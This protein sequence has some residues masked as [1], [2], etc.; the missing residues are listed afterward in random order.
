M[1]YEHQIASGTPWLDRLVGW[2]RLGDNVVIR[3]D[4]LQE[5]RVLAQAFGRVSARAGRQVVYF[6][7]G[8]HP[9]ILEPGD[10]V[11]V[12]EANPAPGFDSFS[13]RLNT[14]IASL[15]RRVFYVFDSLSS[16]VEEWA[17]D[18]SLGNF[19][20]VTCPFLFELETVAFFTLD[21]ARH[22]NATVAR[23]ENTT[24]VLIDLFIEQ[25]T[26]YVQ[27]LKAQKRFWPGMYLPHRL[28]GD[29]CV[30]VFQA[31]HIPPDTARSPWETVFATAAQWV[32][33]AH[34]EGHKQEQESLALEAARMLLG[35]D[36]H[37]LR[38]AERYF[39]LKDLLQIKQRLIGT[40]HIGGKATGMLLARKIIRCTP[41]LEGVAAALEDHDSFYVGS[42][43]FFTFLVENHLFHTRLRAGAPGPEPGDHWESIEQAFLAGHMPTD[44]TR[45][46]QEMLAYFGD[47][48]IIVRSS[49]LLEDGFGNAFAGKYHSEFCPNQ[50]TPAERLEALL[51]AVKRVYASTL[52]PD[53][54]A[55]RRKRQLEE[56]DEQMG[57]LIQRVSGRRF[58]QW[59]F[60][61]LAGV[62]F[63]RNLYAWNTRIDP[64]KGLIRL[65]FGLGTSAVNRVG[66]GYP[67]LVAISHPLL[68]PE[69]G[70]K[71][72]KYSQHDMEAID[73]EQNQL[74]TIPV[75]RILRYR[76]YPGLD[77]LVSLLRDEDLY[78][79]FYRNFVVEPG[80]KLVLTFHNLLKNTRFIRLMDQMLSALEQVYETPV[81][82][83]FTVS[84]ENGDVRINLLQCRPL[85]HPSDPADETLEDPPGDCLFE[86]DKFM[87]GGRATNVHV[88]RLH[89]PRGVRPLIGS[90]HQEEPGAGDRQDQPGHAAPGRRG[91]ADGAGSLG[92]QQPGTG[93]ERHVRGHQPRGGAGGN[94]P[95]GHRPLA[96]GL[97]RDALLPRHRGGEHLVSGSVSA[98]E[99]VAD[100]QDRSESAAVGFPP[101][102]R[103][104]RMLKMVGPGT[105]RSGSPHNRGRLAAA[106]AGGGVF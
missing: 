13:K 65:V 72:A 51:M 63:S 62:A 58:Q 77:L 28:E 102:P 38:L 49:S 2:L 17:T 71:I 37:V 88:H 14:S 95:P 92:K 84:V 99:G 74:A 43:V 103:I 93:S 82:T 12:I 9:P 25:G 79:P 39:D 97:V 8:N 53:A 23:I 104:R 80:E 41:G 30:S 86:T 31:A 59:F 16:L 26:R 48:P 5:Y 7:F 21:R 24:Q 18:E 6:R 34:E 56:S 67:R 100:V 35:Q 87:C 81:D 3:T 45:H 50:G 85:W 20:Q 70:V 36:A 89:R 55:Y 105:D 64:G 4:S 1:Y 57:V 69:I 44:I 54:L 90:E 66:G 29:N 61:T 42:D 46:L 96:R 27:V 78:E 75:E 68:R 47:T 83:E 32:E 22:A 33:A 73:L 40:G 76:H 19:F 15:G 98:P 101:V 11:T 60:P 52:N 91:A 94:R 10:P 106:G